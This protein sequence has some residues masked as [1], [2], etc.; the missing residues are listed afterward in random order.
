MFKISY[1]WEVLPTIARKVNITFEL[2]I[3]ATIFALLI[4]I[5]V[6]IISY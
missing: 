1:F 5:I 6:A 2:T 3:V 4:G